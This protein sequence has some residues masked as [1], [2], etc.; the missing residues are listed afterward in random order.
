[1]PGNPK[2]CREHAK[3]CWRLSM[4]ARTAEAAAV[5][6]DLAKTWMR[7]ATDL[8]RAQLVL[9]EHP[10]FPKDIVRRSLSR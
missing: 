3:E 8:E 2:E 1:V 9:D 6:E 4:S 7:L 10:E 5:F